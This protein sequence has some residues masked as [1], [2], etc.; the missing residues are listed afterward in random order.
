MLRDRGDDGNGNPILAAV[1][2]L[3]FE[4]SYFPVLCALWLSPCLLSGCRVSLEERI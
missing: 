4:V 3:Q 2:Q 1:G